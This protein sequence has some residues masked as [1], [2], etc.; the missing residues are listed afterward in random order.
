MHKRRHRL[1]RWRRVI[2]NRALA[3]GF[4]FCDVEVA[5]QGHALET[6]DFV[7]LRTVAR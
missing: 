2:S 5:K 7:N 1:K 4:G 3:A 6:D